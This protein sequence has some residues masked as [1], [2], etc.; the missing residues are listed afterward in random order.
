[1]A[2]RTAHRRA[3]VKPVV[4]I[5]TQLTLGA[6]HWALGRVRDVRA[7]AGDPT[8]EVS[9]VDAAER[10]LS[11]GQWA[12]VFNDRGRFRARVALPGA[13]RQ[14]VAVATGIYWNKLS[15]GRCNVN[16]TTSSALTD[17][18]GGA[19]FFDN[20]VDVRHWEGDERP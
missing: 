17:M 5:G 19:T 6:S 3:R 14:G 7:V 11:D 4:T 2:Y 13:V 10:H 8:I 9:A 20:L 1:M 12:E 18:G 15:P 16:H